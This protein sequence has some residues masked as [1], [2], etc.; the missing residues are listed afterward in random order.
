MSAADSVTSKH[1]T[2]LMSDNCNQDRQIIAEIPKLDR[3]RG[4]SF[5]RTKLSREH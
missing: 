3:D 2:Q 4:Q 1:L 5:C